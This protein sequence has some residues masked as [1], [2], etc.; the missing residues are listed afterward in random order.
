MNSGPGTAA[1]AAWALPESRSTPI[2]TGGLYPKRIASVVASSRREEE[3]VRGGADAQSDF[4]NSG[5]AQRFHLTVQKKPADR[6]G[7]ALDGYRS[8]CEPGVPSV[9]KKR[10]V[11]HEPY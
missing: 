2:G 5:S 8:R 10:V 7:A 9:D 4:R 3:Q 11:K 6:L 1:A